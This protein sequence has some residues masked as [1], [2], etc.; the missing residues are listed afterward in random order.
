M[1]A[2]HAETPAPTPRCPPR[3][4]A[5]F[6]LARRLLGP[7]LS[8]V[9]NYA[10]RY[11]QAS[12]EHAELRETR[13]H[14]H[15]VSADL[16]AR[17][18]LI[19]WTSCCGQNRRASRRS[20]EPP[21]LD[22]RGRRARRASPW[23]ACFRLCSGALRRELEIKAR[24]LIHY[25]SESFHRP[26]SAHARRW[27]HPGLR[28]PG[29]APSSPC[30]PTPSSSGRLEPEHR[31][32]A[33][34]AGSSRMVVADVGANIGL[35]TLVMAF[36]WSVGPGVQGHRLRARGR[37]PRS[38]LEKMKYPTAWSWSRCAIISRRWRSWGCP[39]FH[40]SDII[41]QPASA[42]GRPARGREARTIEVE[43]VRLDDVAPAK[44]SRRGRSRS[45][46]APSWTS[47]P[48]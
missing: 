8:P 21:K 41:G 40:V 10:R 2:P 39:T 43:V 20:A 42:A 29:P 35:L 24:P 11:L 37:A 15:A 27:L 31:R 25:D 34:P 17:G 19:G 44:R 4:A 1:R 16:R 26:P 23:P 5:G 32:R 33:A 47:W 30:W 7:L 48:A 38:N 45:P 14:L 18:A 28:P 22:A 12:V 13:Q 9:A 36:A 6:G 46:K 3:R